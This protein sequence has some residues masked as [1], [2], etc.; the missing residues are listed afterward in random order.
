MSLIMDALR[1]S[2]RQRQR[3]LA[4]QLSALAP[5]PRPARG[6]APWGLIIGT[7]LVLNAA[8]GAALL[9]RQDRATPP[10]PPTTVTAVRPA[11]NQPHPQVRSL[12]AEAAAGAPAPA[13][14]GQAGANDDTGTSAPSS[15]MPAAQSTASSASTDSADANV[16]PLDALPDG[17]R[18]SL[19]TLHLDVHSYSPN[20]AQRFVLINMHRYQ[21]GDTLEAGPRVLRITPEGVILEYQ[22][23][24]FLLPRQ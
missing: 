3:S 14:T 9:W 12:A 22:G 24:R 20:P 23:R 7:L 18:Q 2:E 16:M 21:E 15:S 19:P 6:R 11:Q 10:P 5:S 17:F 1:K 8:L 4:G 13:T